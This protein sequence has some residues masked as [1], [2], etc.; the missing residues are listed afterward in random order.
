VYRDA[1]SQAGT[2]RDRFG[3]RQHVPTSGR[4]GRY[5]RPEHGLRRRCDRVFEQSSRSPGTA[6]RSHRSRRHHRLLLGRGLLR[7]GPARGR[8]RASRPRPGAGAR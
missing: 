1:R 8:V 5:R 2:C 4:L 7:R 3:D 6:D